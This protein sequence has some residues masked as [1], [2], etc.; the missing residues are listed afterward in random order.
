MP[1]TH[2]HGAATDLVTA[3]G[4]DPLSLGLYSEKMKKFN[5]FFHFKG[6]RRVV[7]P[8]TAPTPI[9]WHVFLFFALVLLL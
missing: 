5:L 8:S 7:D 6:K 9:L 3:P 1:E 2:Q 4:S